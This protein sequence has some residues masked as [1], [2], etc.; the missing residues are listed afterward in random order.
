MLVLQKPVAVRLFLNDI[1]S[2]PGADLIPE[3]ALQ[4]LD[5]QVALRQPFDIFQKLL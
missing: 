2:R 5:S 1:G 4:Q 3:Q